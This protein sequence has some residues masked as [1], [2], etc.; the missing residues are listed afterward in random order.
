[1]RGEGQVRQVRP[2]VGAGGRRS[3]PV[4]HRSFNLCLWLPRQSSVQPHSLFAHFCL[5]IPSYPVLIAIDLNPSSLVPPPSLESNSHCWPTPS[6]AMPALRSRTLQRRGDD[7]GRTFSI[8]FAVVA[9]LV[10]LGCLIWGIILPKFRKKNHTR[11]ANSLPV[12]HGNRRAVPEFPSHPALLRGFRKTPP[13]PPVRRYDP[14]V[15][16]PFPNSPTELHSL[17]HHVAPNYRGV[18]RPSGAPC[19]THGLFTPLN[20]PLPARFEHACSGRGGDAGAD[21]VMNDMQEYIL[22]VPEPLVLK[23]RPA[24]RPPPLTRQLER[25]PLPLG[26]ALKA[27]L[28]H[29]GELVQEQEQRGSK[30]TSDTYGTPCPTPYHS[31]PSKAAPQ[32][33]LGV[34]LQRDRPAHSQDRPVHA[35]LTTQGLD[36]ENKKIVRADTNGSWGGSEHWN[37]ESILK[38]PVP[39]E[40]AGTVTRPKTPV[41]EMREWFDRAVSHS[42][43][44]KVSGMR[45]YTPSSNPF[46]TPGLSSTA[47]TSPAYSS[48]KNP[49]PS[50]PLRTDPEAFQKTAAIP[51]VHRRRRTP[52]S[53]VLPSPEDI[54]KWQ[55]NTTQKRPR[56]NK[57][58]KAGRLNF[59]S[60]SNLRPRKGPAQR[61]SLSSLSTIFKP[62]IAARSKHSQAASSA[63]SRDTKGASF[64]GSPKAD[65]TPHSR[66]ELPFGLARPSSL[67]MDL[68]QTKID[69]WDLHTG[70]LDA[71]VLTPSALKRS[72][73]DHGP[74]GAIQHDLHDN[75]DARHE[76]FEMELS[77]AGRFV[78]HIRIA[79]SSDDIFSDERSG[80]RRDKACKNAARMLNHRP[81]PVVVGEA[82]R[83][84]APG[85]GEWI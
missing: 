33:S 1:M 3:P 44:E 73:S 23:P 66:T 25:F 21:I 26:C 69:N 81:E 36:G 62:I 56:R 74:R 60:L 10:V 67:S 29:P 72:L 12:F 2:S 71:S 30:S 64:L 51:E 77:G 48:K 84:T 27:G 43:T 31:I 61:H 47:P 16:S 58:A 14:R 18:L 19:N 11:P 50:T 80:I 4:P 39:L 53:V 20:A 54:I 17:P 6:R 22:P 8:I 52:S 85:G 49:A 83:G 75:V 65:G 37:S 41:S 70:D 42:T 28:I 9:L 38:R 35:V 5:R 82:R 79:R 34:P 32:Q 57:R 15:E 68:L 76:P 63:Y 40:R 24:G 78:P 45:G 13:P 59:V 7:T 46:T 55:S